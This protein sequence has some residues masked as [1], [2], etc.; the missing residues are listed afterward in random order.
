MVTLE[1]G[2]FA[3]TKRLRVAG[4]TAGEL[5]AHWPGL[6]AVDAPDPRAG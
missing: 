5:A 6:V 3:R 4:R 1:A 2:A